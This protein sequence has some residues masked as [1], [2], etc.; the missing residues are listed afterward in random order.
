[1]LEAGDEGEADDDDSFGPA[2]RVHYLF[3]D[4]MK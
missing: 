1:M 3:I 2:E 4:A